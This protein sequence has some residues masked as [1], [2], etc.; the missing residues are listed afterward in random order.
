MKLDTRFKEA[1][2]VALAF[3]MVYGIALKMSW[4]N[5]SWAAFGVAMI[6]L[7]T[8]GQSIHKG[9]DRLAGTIP[10]CI[11][12]LV[13]LSLAPQNRWLFMF[14]AAA[15]V[16]FI[17]Y[18]MIRSKN[19]PYFW[20]V[21]G[22]VCLIILLTGPGSSDSDFEHAVFRTLE[23]AMGVTVYTLV[24]VFIWP[25]SN[26]G[27][28]KTAID[29]LASTF[30][31]RNRSAWKVMSG[32]GNGEELQGLHKQSVQQLDQLAQ[33]LIAEGSESYEVHELRPAFER[34]HQ[35]SKSLMESQ[36]RLETSLDDL[37]RIDVKTLLP[38]MQNFMNTQDEHLEEIRQLL[39]GGK[40]EP[41]PGSFDLRAD[42]DAIHRLSGFDLAALMVIKNELEKLDSLTSDM[43]TCI[44]DIQADTA[45]NKPDPVRDPRN[46]EPGLWLPVPDRDHFMG[47]LFAMLCTTG[48]FLVWIFINPPGHA[49]WIELP[50]IVAMMVG[51]TPQIRAS[52]FFKPI[53]VMLTLA[54]AIYVLVLPQLT[55]FAGLGLVLFLC[56]FIA[57]YF[58]SGIA[59]LAG[60]VAI[61]NMITIENQQTYNFAAQAN[62]LVFTLFAF[63]FVY[64]VSYLLSSSRPEKTV[65]KMTGRFFRSAQFMVSQMTRDPA[66]KM[67]WVDQWKIAYY[68]NEMETLPAKLGAWGKA[69]DHKLFPNTTQE[70][71]ARLVTSLQSLVY[72]IDELFAARNGTRIAANKEQELTADL[73]KWA[74]GMA[75]T[76]E[77]WSKQPEAREEDKQAQSVKAWLSELENKA[78]AFMAGIGDGISEDDGEKLYRLL[79]GYRGVTNAAVS[80]TESA[81]NIDWNQ[82]REERFS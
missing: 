75:V 63:L 77:K 21:A 29:K 51:V 18:M 66:R 31:D 38:G 50:A 24:T 57:C 4:M 53:A 43:L 73:K 70:Q 60:L 28:I 3:A 48:G 13:I 54:L 17:V 14:L 23:T 72:R 9:F 36:D 5:P 79:G 65:L 55:S 6:A 62:I 22:F 80:Y 10:G 26:A 44:Q 42:K 2:K 46:H 59:R 30:R 68:R 56:A 49:A 69:I 20:N 34:F 12:A 33:A 61:I 8:A 40:P 52:T 45:L 32:Q 37:A 71:L 47:A 11:S 16:F 82:W 67:T 81:R 74:Q 7:P 58:F 1:F 15:W 78:E 25:S 27:A 41:G 19:H 76:F 39:K 64:V 35:L